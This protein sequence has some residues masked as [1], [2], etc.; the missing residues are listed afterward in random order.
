MRVY[1]QGYLYDENG[2]LLVSN[3]VTYSI[4]SGIEP[5][6]SITANLPTQIDSPW[7]APITR[8]KT[9]LVFKLRVANAENRQSK[10]LGVDYRPLENDKQRQTDWRNKVQKQLDAVKL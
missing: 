5:G 3:P 4:A 9:G 2:V 8:E 1:L 10:T 6:A 7:A